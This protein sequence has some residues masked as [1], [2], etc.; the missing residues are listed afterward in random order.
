MKKVVCIVGTILAASVLDAETYKLGDYYYKLDSEKQEARL[1]A[2]DSS[3]QP[4]E[5]NISTVMFEDEVY[6]VTSV[7]TEAFLECKSLVAVSFPCLKTICDGA[8]REC[9]AL[10]SVSIP[11]AMTFGFQSFY[12]CSAI[13]SLSFPLATYVNDEAFRGCEGLLSI[14]IP[15]AEYVGECAFTYCNS[16]ESI[17]IPLVRTIGNSA[18][19]YC[20]KLEVVQAA[21]ATTIGKYAFHDCKKLWSLLI[22]SAKTIGEYGI[23]QCP[24][25]EKLFLLSIESLEM[26]TLGDCSALDEVYFATPIPPTFGQYCFIRNSTTLK[27]PASAK[28]KDWEGA[29]GST[30]MPYVKVE[31]YDPSVI[32][33]SLSEV[34]TAVGMRVAGRYV[35]LDEY[36]SSRMEVKMTAGGLEMGKE[37]FEKVC[38]AFGVTATLP[39]VEKVPETTVEAIEINDGK[40]TLGIAVKR[41]SSL[42]GGNWE[43]VG[44]T[45]VTIDAP[46][47]SGFFVIESKK[48]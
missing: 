39:T 45:S 14:S 36:N 10:A 35:T 34:K 4:I 11:N 19:E 15:K 8:F 47:E 40:A 21:N 26:G 17:Y 31:K 28:E 41:A 23:F 16:L 30:C 3:M 29:L 38:A 32:A 33:G 18:F 2:Y 20:P 13:K 25:L 5:I 44:S 46:G 24:L 42:V 27:I 9:N 12:G 43:K 22:P 6:A 7:G 1:T 48:P 37:D